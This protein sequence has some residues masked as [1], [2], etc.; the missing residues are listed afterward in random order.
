MLKNRCQIIASLDG[1]KRWGWYMDPCI[2]GY[3]KALGHTSRRLLVYN[4][5]LQ[6]QKHI[7]SSILFSF[8]ENLSL[9]AKSP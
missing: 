3:T 2:D 6:A 9:A 1:S 8:K 4:K 7:D 5:S